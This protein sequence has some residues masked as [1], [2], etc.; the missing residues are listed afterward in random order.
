MANIFDYLTW[1]GDVPFS[2]DPFNE[3]D[4]LVLSELAYTDFDGIVPQGGAA[5]SLQTVCDAF[6]ARHTEEELLS[7]RAYTA[8]APLLLRGMLSGERFRD[9]KLSWYVNEIS[10]DQ[11]LQLS[12]VTVLLPDSTAFV[13]FRGTDGTVVGWKE[14]FNFSFQSQ[15]EGQGRAVAYL[16]RVGKALA[17]PLYIGGHSK[18]GNLAV[19][20]ASFCEKEIRERIL[21]VYSNDGPGFRREIVEK[22]G[23]LQIL[24]KVTRIVPDTSVIGML[25][26]SKSMPMVV[27]SAA[28]GIAQHDGFSWQV[29]RNRFEAA[30]LT[31]TGKLLE[32]TVGGWLEQMDDDARRTLTDTVFTLVESTGMEK[33]SEISAQKLKSAEAMLSSLREI[34]KENQ[35]EVLSLFTQ[36]GQMG[37]AAA[38]NY[39]KNLVRKKT[40]DDEWED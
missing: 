24:P 30:E 11:A 32:Q 29:Q 4:N 17:C 6:F 14:D 10:K 16:N 15:T 21:R 35:Q 40:G 23:Y 38:A 1:R 39:L 5:V 18:G 26:T 33:F 31:E 19:Y 37:G 20:A 12:A 7:L 3:V 2:V 34:P 9:A 22:P 36:L 8:K 27:K 28:S 13:A 25:M